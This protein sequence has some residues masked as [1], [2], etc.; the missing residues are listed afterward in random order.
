METPGSIDDIGGLDNLKGWLGRQR[1]AFSEEA[2]AFGIDAPKGVLFIGPPGTGKSLSVKTIAASWQLPLI[3]FDVGRMMGS[4]VGESEGNLRHAIQIA[5]SVAPCIVM[6][7]ELEKAVAGSGSDLSGVTTR[8]VGQLLTW[9]TEKTAPV[10]VAATAND[11]TSLPPE[12]LRKGRFDEIWV[13]DLPNPLERE[14]VLAV[15]LTKRKRDPKQFDL[16]MLA[17][18]ADHFSGAELEQTVVEALRYAFGENREVTT[19]DLY[20]AIE[21]TTPLAVTFSERIKQLR[22]WAKGRARFASS[23]PTTAKPAARVLDLEAN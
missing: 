20:K 6:V 5:E 1:R 21:E 4:L 8:M 2:R 23:T 7:D 10:Y 3:R 9:M 19:Q 18:R 17:S 22:E 13:V 16:S 14:A 12:L 15:H 11:V